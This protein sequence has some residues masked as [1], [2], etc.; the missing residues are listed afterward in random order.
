MKNKKNW[1]MDMQS[2]DEGRSRVRGPVLFG[3]IAGIHALAIMGFLVIQGCGTKQPMVEPPPA[4]VMPPRADIDV[5]PVTALPRPTFQPPVAVE[6]A[7]ASIEAASVQTYTVASGDSLSKIANRFGVTAREIAQLNGVKDPNK[8]RVGQSLKLP[9][10]AS[11]SGD[12]AAVSAPKAAA[13]APKAAKKAAAPAVAGSGEYVV[14]SGDSLSKIAVKH[15]TTVKALKEVNHLQSDLIRLGQKLK[16]PSGASAK[17]TPKAA[18]AAKEKD[19]SA[20]AAPAPVAPSPEAMPAAPEAA[21]VAEPAAPSAVV[22]PAPV[23]DAAAS[24]SDVQFQYTVQPGETLD[25]V[26]RSFS[27]L[28]EDILKLNNLSSDATLSGGQRIRIPMSAP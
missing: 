23:P 10:Y 20:V 27:V 11:A 22:A 7:P 9:S 25:D 1:S 3:I 8:I 21:P 16:L 19:S 13:S 28:K 2:S 5:P 24:V 26:A 14:Q 15:G 12:S 6:Q 4:P 17:A 18:S